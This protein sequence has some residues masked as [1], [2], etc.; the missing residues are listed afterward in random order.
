ML[1]FLSLD[2]VREDEAAAG[3]VHEAPWTA[4]GE[5]GRTLIQAI[6]HLPAFNTPAALASVAWACRAVGVDAPFL[7]RE[8]GVALPDRAW[9]A[10]SHIDVHKPPVKPLKHR[11]GGGRTGHRK[12]PKA[13]LKELLYSHSHERSR[14]VRPGGVPMLQRALERSKGSLYD[15]AHTGIAQQI[16]RSTF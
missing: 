4:W 13:T 6:T 15:S 2:V 9:R 3:E 16:G 11:R 7:Q 14:I 1:A 10:A 12:L 5:I 8:L